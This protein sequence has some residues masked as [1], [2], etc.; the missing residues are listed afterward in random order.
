MS[1]AQQTTPAASALRLIVAG[2]IEVVRKRSTPKG[3]TFRT[4]IRTPAAD[5]YSVP[6]T[7][8]VRSRRRLGAEGQA[9]EVECDLLGYARSFDDKASGEPV[10]TAEHVLQAA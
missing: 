9:V 5:P 8:E 3:D 10:K 2:R 6:G 4:L 1:Q 7:F